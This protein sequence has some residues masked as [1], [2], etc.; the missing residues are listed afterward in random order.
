[1]FRVADFV[2]LSFFFACCVRQNECEVAVVMQINGFRIPWDT[3]FVELNSILTGFA[4]CV[5]CI[6]EMIE[7]VWMLWPDDKKLLMKLFDYIM[8]TRQISVSFMVR[9]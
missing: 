8:L 4:T 3:C 6:L 2:I 1:M 5:E 7:D 9:F